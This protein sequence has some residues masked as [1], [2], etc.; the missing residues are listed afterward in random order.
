MM[1][2]Q[3][4]RRELLLD[5]GLKLKVYFD[6]QGVPTIGVGRNLQAKGI[7]EATAAQMLEEDIDEAVKDLLT[8]P[9]FLNLSEPRQRAIV[10]MRFNLGFSGFR[11]FKKMIKSLE[12]SDYD[13]ASSQ[14]MSSKWASQVKGRAFRLAQMIKTGLDDAR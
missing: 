10:N 9:W 13:S 4:L 6:T 1:D 2:R 11:E 7:S 3:K 14:M 8:F 12:E 5:E